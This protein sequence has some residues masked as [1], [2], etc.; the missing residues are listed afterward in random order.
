MYGPPVSVAAFYGGFPGALDFDYRHGLYQFPCNQTPAVAFS[1][2]GQIWNISAEKYVGLYIVVSSST[3]S[4]TFHSFNL[5]QTQKG[6]SMCIGALV[7]QDMG[8]GTNVWL[9]GDSFMKNVY[10]IFSFER[11]SV[12]FASLS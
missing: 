8:L 11:N 5:G 3:D 1:W 4:L 7:G 6:S 9:I 2:G 10:S 12:G